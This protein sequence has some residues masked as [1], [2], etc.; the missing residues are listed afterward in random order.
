MNI[1]IL[2]PVYED[3]HSL[4]KLVQ[5]IDSLIAGSSDLKQHEVSVVVVDDA[6]CQQF[7]PDEFELL[8][9]SVVK[10]IQVI[11]LLTNLGHQRAIATGLSCM[12]M[13]DE[14]DGILVM[15]SDGEDSPS[16]AISLIRIFVKNPKSIVIAHRTKRSESFLF[17]VG[18]ACYQ[19][20]F[21]VLAGSRLPFGNFL[22]MPKNV[23]RQ[24]IY[25]S[26]IWNHLAAT[27]SRSS[28][29]RKFVKT[30]RGSR[31]VGKSSMSFTS[32]VVH[33]LSAMSIYAD[34]IAARLIFFSGILAVFMLLGVGFSLSIR[35]FTD[36][37]IPGWTS[38]V[39]G[40]LGLGL[41]LVMGFA[42]L[43]AFVTL[44]FRQGISFI[45]KIDSIRFVKNV[46]IWKNR[47]KIS[48]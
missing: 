10:K 12:S 46:M 18:Y 39:I 20:C 25:S 14:F 48:M 2:M 44:Q 24:L 28:L 26:G 33:G 30:I 36:F 41:L 42:I 1:A 16:D 13:D 17:R 27:I 37:A 47:S 29:E 23:F 6:S 43:L 7:S 34:R 15:D 11:T 5:D 38:Q 31:Y 3:W 21:V 9:L 35:L 4:K 22:L 40:M 32:L 8:S 19:L 45:P